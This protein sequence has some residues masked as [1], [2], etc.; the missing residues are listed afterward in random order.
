MFFDISVKRQICT[1]ECHRCTSNNIGFIALSDGHRGLHVCLFYAFQYN[2]I[3]V[4]NNSIDA[5]TK[6]IGSFCLLCS[7]I[8]FNGFFMSF[9]TVPLM[10]PEFRR[11]TQQNNCFTLL[12]DRH[13]W[14][15]L[16]LLMFY[17]I[18]YIRMT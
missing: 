8:L 16:C 10:Y 13:C 12:V 18:P 15:H 11:C 2:S 7:C 5:R 14:L 6:N 17:Q 4:L 9:I 3:D 1:Q